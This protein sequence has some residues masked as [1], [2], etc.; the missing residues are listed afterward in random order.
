MTTTNAIPKNL[1]CKQPPANTVLVVDDSATDREMVGRIIEKMDN[2]HAAFAQNGIEALSVL[3]EQKFD[4]VL[5]DLLMPEMDGLELVESIRV[6]YPQMPVILMTAFGSEEIA[7]SALQKGA[8]SYIPKRTLVHDLGE[9]LQLVVNSHRLY[10]AAPPRIFVSHSTKDR[11][12]VE[13]EIVSLLE[14]HRIKTW[15]SKADIRT[16][17]EWERSIIEG[18]RACEWFLVVMSAQAAKSAWVRDEVHWAMENRPG[19]LIPVLI[20]DCD[21]CDFHLRMARL[22]HVDYRTD[23]EAAREQLLSVFTEH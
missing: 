22:Q 16:A 17:A 23:I 18:L 14:Q 21:P 15:Y 8:A 7:I 12:F 3:K 9:T 1:I 4:V 5:T 10:H 13:R 19:K 2:W 11:D 20:G 6:N